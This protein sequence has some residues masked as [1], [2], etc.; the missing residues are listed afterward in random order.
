MMIGFRHAKSQLKSLQTSAAGV[1][2]T[3]KDQG[4]GCIWESFRKR[5]LPITWNK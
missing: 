3:N 5:D 1:K 4:Q 2:I